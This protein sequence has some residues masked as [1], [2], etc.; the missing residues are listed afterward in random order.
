MPEGLLAHTG[1]PDVEDLREGVMRHPDVILI[2]EWTISTES[3][4]R[5]A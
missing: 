4:P 1:T 5:Y 3:L 2:A